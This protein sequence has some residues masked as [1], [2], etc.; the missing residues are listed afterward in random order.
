MTIDDQIRV[1][2]RFN[3]KVDRLTQRGFAEES[4][5]SGSIV[6]WR[7]GQGWDGIHFGPSG[8]TVEATVLTLRFFLNNNEK[9]SLSNMDDLYSDLNIEPQLIM[10]LRNIRNRVNSYLNTR[11]NLSI[12]EEGPMTHGQI[13]DLFIN[14]DLAHANNPTTEANFRSISKTA[15]F[16][17]FQIEFT[18]TIQLFVSALNAIQKVNCAALEQLRGGG[19]PI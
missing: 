12:S 18:T 8:K 6:E 16:P 10:R 15:L 3:E 11:S 14:G 19:K 1:L 9:T 4:K 2:E 13:L 5:G 17:L 7:R